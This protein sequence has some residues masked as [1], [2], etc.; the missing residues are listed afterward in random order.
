MVFDLFRYLHILAGFTALLIFWIPIVTKKGGKIHVRAGWVYV[1]AMTVVAVSALFMG[2]WR[3]FI[4]PGS[5]SEKIAFSWF[6]IF[7]S[8]LSSASAWYGIRVLKF[9]NR[10]AAHKNRMDLFVSLLLVV[11]GICMSL[12]GYTRHFPLLIWFPLIGIFTGF[13]QLRYWIRPPKTR[14]H[15]WFEHLTSM[16]ACCIAT[17]TAFTVFGAPRLLNLSS[18]NPILWFLPTIVIVP[19]MIAMR[20]SYTKKFAR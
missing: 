19:V 9:K 4:D 8:I 10:N 17:I 12:Y 16:M 3:I 2:I 7:I 13:T 11:S 15:W 20:R 14:M 5:D 18:V 1:G 6:L